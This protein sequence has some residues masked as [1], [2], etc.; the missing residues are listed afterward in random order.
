MGLGILTLVLLDSVKWSLHEEEALVKA[1]LGALTLSMAYWFHSTTT[2]R[3]PWVSLL[4]TRTAE[5]RR[6]EAYSS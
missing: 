4:K 5:M 2:K 1:E 6:R 3:L